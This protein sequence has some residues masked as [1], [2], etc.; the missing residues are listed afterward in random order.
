MMTHFV[1][2]TATAILCTFVHVLIMFY[3]IGTGIDIREAVKDDASLSDRFVPLTREFKR[4]VFPLATLSTA[5]IVLAALMGGEVH[6]RIIPRVSDGLF[7]VREVAA[8]WIHGAVVLLAVVLNATAFVAELR[9]ARDNRAV[10]DEI[11][12]V[13][14]DAAPTAGSA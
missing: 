10:I 3:L 14:G 2:G 5:F 13:L 12:R 1:L 4:R 7:P 11:N 8:W 9:V 6:S